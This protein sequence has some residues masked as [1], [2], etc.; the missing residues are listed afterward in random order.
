MAVVSEDTFHHSTNSIYRPVA[1]SLRE[2]QEALLEKLLDSP[3]PIQQRPEDRF[4][5]AYLIFF[6]LGI[7]G[8]LPWNFFVTAK[9][10]WIYKFSNSSSPTA[11]E[12]AEGSDILV[13]RLVSR[14]PKRGCGATGLVCAILGWL[15]SQLRNFCTLGSWLPPTP[16]LS[17]ALCWRHPV[18][19]G[20]GRQSQP[21]DCFN[22]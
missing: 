17:C 20:S 12:D 4:N 7:G 14:Q 2:D 3:A 8:M 21:P 13:R 9:E 15:H 6:S 19:L 18:A 1:G 16:V 22:C 11:G 10:Y 5:G